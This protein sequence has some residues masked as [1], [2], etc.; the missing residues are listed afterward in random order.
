MASPSDTPNVMARSPGARQSAGG[1]FD[2]AVFASALIAINLVAAV[3]FAGSRIGDAIT[4]LVGVVLM[5][6]VVARVELRGA[7]GRLFG[8][9]AALVVLYMIQALHGGL[10]DGLKNAILVVLCL[11]VFFYHLMYWRQILA[12]PG[13]VIMAVLAALAVVAYSLVTDAF[14]NNAINGIAVYFLFLAGFSILA[15]VPLNQAALV[16]CAIFVSA[17]ILSV[18][19]DHRAM[20]G[21]SFG[22]MLAYLAFLFGGVRRW[23]SGPIFVVIISISVLIFV[24]FAI[25]ARLPEWAFIND[26]V[27]ENTGRRA[28]SGR[29]VIWPLLL[30]MVSESPIAGYG[31]GARPAQFFSFEYSAHNYYLQLVFQVG[32]FGLVFVLGLLWRLYRTLVRPV[33]MSGAVGFVAAALLVAIL[34]NCFVVMFMQNQIIA[35]IPFWSLMGLGAGMA[36][37]YRP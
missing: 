32:I 31:S 12:S 37:Q 22:G 6:V 7:P 14:D 18:L 26:F 36:L 3:V 27:S 33:R 25:L 24:Y 11:G 5:G 19:N 9:F 30:F 2:V 17:M 8:W 13:F 28:L 16:G 21:L 29:D 35:A 20:A 4:L 15:S 10:A 23:M 1:R 34:H